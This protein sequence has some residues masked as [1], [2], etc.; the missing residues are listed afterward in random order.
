MQLKKLLNNMNRVLL[1]NSSLIKSGVLDT[2]YFVIDENTL[3]DD[4]DLVRQPYHGG[5]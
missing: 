1:N 4:G 3:R 5:L 2:Q